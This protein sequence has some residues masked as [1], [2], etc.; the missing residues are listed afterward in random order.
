[1]EEDGHEHAEEKDKDQRN[2]HRN[3]EVPLVSLHIFSESIVGITYFERI[4]CL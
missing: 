3:L 4:T 1:M 2:Q